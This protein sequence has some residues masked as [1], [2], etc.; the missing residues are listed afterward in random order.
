[1]PPSCTHVRTQTL[2]NNPLHWPEIT[3]QCEWTEINWKPEYVQK[4]KLEGI[5]NYF[6]FMYNLNAQNRIF[7]SNV[8][9]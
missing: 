4:V 7:H 1:M 9:V 2:Y 6:E 5:L 3:V 8:E